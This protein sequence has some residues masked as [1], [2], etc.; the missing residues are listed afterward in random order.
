MRN[1]DVFIF[2]WKS[3]KLIKL[4]HVKYDGMVMYLKRFEAGHFKL[5]EYGSESNSYSMEW[6]D[7]VT[8]KCFGDNYLP[9][10]QKEDVSEF[11]SGTSSFYSN[12]SIR[13]LCP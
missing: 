4:P 10:T 7:F 9:Q 1:D 2:I 13:N 11:H 12:R 5:P 6:R 3:R 8:G